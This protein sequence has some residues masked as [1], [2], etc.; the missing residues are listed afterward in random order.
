MSLNFFIRRRLCYTPAEHLPNM[1]KSLL[2]MAEHCLFLDLKLF[3][4]GRA[5]IALVDGDYVIPAAEHLPNRTE[6]CLFYPGG[7]FIFSQNAGKK[8]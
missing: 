3:A 2:N 1:A 5:L 6:N 7:A 4:L 8:F